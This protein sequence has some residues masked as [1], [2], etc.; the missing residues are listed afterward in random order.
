V[1]GEHHYLM[2]DICFV[3]ERCTRCTIFTV[4]GSRGGQNGIPRAPFFRFDRSETAEMVP[5]VHHFR[6]LQLGFWEKRCTRCTNSTGFSQGL[7]QNG[8]PGAPIRP[9]S[10]RDYL[11]TV[12]QMHQFDGFQSGIASKWCTSCTNWTTFRQDLPQTGAP[13][14]PI[15]L[16][17]AKSCIKM[18]HYLNHLRTS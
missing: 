15:W 2:F 10:V 8:A 9:V 11:K 5:S 7:P 18:V 12:H 3:Q 17:S 13:A 6:R 4:F 16:V 14:A 1:H